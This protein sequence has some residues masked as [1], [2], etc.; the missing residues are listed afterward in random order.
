[1]KHLTEKPIAALV[2]A[3][4]DNGHH[5]QV[6]AALVEAII[7]RKPDA[8]HAAVTEAITEIYDIE[9]EL[10]YGGPLADFC[11]DVRYVLIEV[12]KTLMP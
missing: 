7:N 8:I 6:A 1:M 12:Q 11:R 5:H 3:C 2:T 9:C 4:F 10:S